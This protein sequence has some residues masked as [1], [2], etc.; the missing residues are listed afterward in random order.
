MCIKKGSDSIVKENVNNYQK[1]LI[2]KNDIKDEK[3]IVDNLLTYNKDTLTYACGLYIDG[4][5]F[6]AVCV[7]FAQITGKVTKIPEILIFG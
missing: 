7:R 1:A 6:A 2:L 3:G 5:F 4:E